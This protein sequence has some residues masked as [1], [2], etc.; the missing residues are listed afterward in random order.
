MVKSKNKVIANPS[1][2]KDKLANYLLKGRPVTEKLAFRQFKLKNLRATIS[3]LRE[4]GYNIV[5][6][7]TANGQL[8]YVIG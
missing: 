4:E 3:D 2:R 6:D 8:K 1:S 5:T 7:R